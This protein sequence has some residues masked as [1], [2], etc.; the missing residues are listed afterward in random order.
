M[1]D[2]LFHLICGPRC[3]NGTKANWWNTTQIL[4]A[5]QK[6]WIP[7]GMVKG[8]TRAIYADKMSCGKSTSIEHTGI[9]LNT[10]VIRVIFWYMGNKVIAVLDKDQQIWLSR[11]GYCITVSLPFRT[12]SLPTCIERVDLTLYSLLLQLIQ[13]NPGD[14]MNEISHLQP[15]LQQ[16][17]TRDEDLLLWAHLSNQ[18]RLQ[19][20]PHHRATNNT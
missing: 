14:T 8:P 12:S 16:M 6:Y 17:Q 20:Y 7:H 3:W 15:Q 18:N 2:F 4:C 10:R 11:K 19:Y 13:E 5:L 9:Q 1:V